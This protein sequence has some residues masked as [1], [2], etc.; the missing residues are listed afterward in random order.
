MSSIEEVADARLIRGDVRELI[1]QA[2]RGLISEQEMYRAI[3][4]RIL[5]AF[6][7]SLARQL[8]SLLDLEKAVWK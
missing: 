5:P 8:D 1:E 3:L 4:L 7:L 6:R 2:E